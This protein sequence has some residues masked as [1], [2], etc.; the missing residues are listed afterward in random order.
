MRNA[1]LSSLVDAYTVAQKAR[2]QWSNR[3]VA[4]SHG[5][6]TQETPQILQAKSYEEDFHKIER[7]A[8]KEFRAELDSELAW[9]WLQS[10]KGIADTL[11]AKLIARIDIERTPRISNLWSLAGFSVVN[12]HAPRLEKGQKRTWDGKLKVAC[13]LCASSFLKCGSPYREHYD[14]AKEKFQ[15]S[16]PDWTKGHVHNA[17]MGKM[18]KHFL[19]DFWIAWRKA[20]G[21]PVSEPYPVA[22]LGHQNDRPSAIDGVKPMNLVRAIEKVKPTREVRATGY[23][24]PK[25]SVRAIERVKPDR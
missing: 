1:N 9:P 2:I 18:I 7:R 25:K 10:Q 20:A 15:R 6:D 13:W 5:S 16:H 17:A 11:A 24:K 22:I 12:G 3:V 19:A 8:Y 14:R 23:V 4:L 21:L